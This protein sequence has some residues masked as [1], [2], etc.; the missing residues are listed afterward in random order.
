[1]ATN[2]VSMLHNVGA[3]GSHVLVALQ[4][5]ETSRPPK[6]DTGGAGSLLQGNGPFV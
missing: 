1:M 3:L 6:G 4:P 2:V 5:L